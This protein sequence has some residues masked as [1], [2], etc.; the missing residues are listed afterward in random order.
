[1]RESNDTLLVCERL[2]GFWSLE[3]HIADD[4]NEWVEVVPKGFGLMYFISELLFCCFGSVFS[5]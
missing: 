4:S 3:Q 1:M 5:Q 2:V